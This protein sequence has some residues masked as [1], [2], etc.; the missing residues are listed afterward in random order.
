MSIFQN[1][2]VVLA[3]CWYNMPM[4]SP[5]EVPPPNKKHGIERKV[6]KRA[7]GMQGRLIDPTT[8]YVPENPVRHQEVWNKDTAFV[9][10][11]DDRVRHNKYTGDLF[12]KSYRNVNGK[13][14]VRWSHP[15]DVE[16]GIRLADHVKEAYDSATGREVERTKGAISLVKDLSV[17]FQ[18]PGLAPLD[19]QLMSEEAAATLAKLGFIDAVKEEKLDVVKKIMRAA[20][21]D[22]KT[23]VNG[24]RS[25]MILSHVWVDLIHELLVEKMTGN[26][27][28]S[29]KA[30]LIRE[31]EFERFVLDQTVSHIDEQTQTSSSFEDRRSVLELKHFV[32][33]YLSSDVVKL[34]PY[35]QVAA[36]SRFLL[37]TTGTQAEFDLLRKYI[38]DKADAYRNTKPLTDPSLDRADK[39]IVLADVRKKII[40]CAEIGELFLHTETAKREEALE[41]YHATHKAS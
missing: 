21:L 19:I 39:I 4:T 26:K 31:R 29:I 30:K 36:I 13:S 37:M 14:L 18:K 32:A 6:L 12:I 15:V 1:L 35:S 38:G 8:V 16:A 28:T 2:S 3:W 23:R 7:G 5:I 34:K 24:P 20:A 41:Q 40:E 10:T 11:T 33:K 25:R 27:Y 17:D 9:F 22:S